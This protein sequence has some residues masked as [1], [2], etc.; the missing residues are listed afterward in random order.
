MPNAI[1]VFTPAFI[2]DLNAFNEADLLRYSASAV[3]ARTAQ[4]L[5]VH[6]ISMD[7][8]SF[9]FRICGQLATRSRKSLNTALLPDTYTTERF[10]GARG[11]EAFLLGFGGAGDILSASIKTAHLGRTF[12]NLVLR[13][14]SEGV[15]RAT[16]YHNQ[17]VT[18][19]FAL[20][21]NAA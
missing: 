17:R 11:P 16:L 15:V 5:A 3:P 2:A 18:Q 10:E 9:E 13:V 19:K 6:R 12:T 21:L 7:T 14:E 20:R 8:G 1:S 4:T